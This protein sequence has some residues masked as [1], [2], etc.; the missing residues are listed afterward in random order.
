MIRGYLTAAGF[1][2][3][4]TYSFI[5]EVDYDKLL[6]PQ[7]SGLR[8]AVRILNPLGDDTNQMRTTLLADV[9]KVM[10][11]NLKRKNKNPRIFEMNKV[12]L[13]KSLPLTDEL[14][15]EKKKLALVIS[16]DGADFYRLKEAVENLFELCRAG[17][18]EMAAGG[19]VYFHPGRKALLYL[20]EQLVGELGE[21]HP[22]VLENF[23]LPERVCAAQVDLGA[24][25]QAMDTHIRFAPLPKYPA[26][27]RDLAVIV[28]RDAQ[29]GVIQKAILQ[30]GGKYIESAELFDVYEGQQLG[31][32]KKSLAYSLSFRSSVSTLAEEDIRRDMERILSSLREHFGAVLRG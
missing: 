11:T 18:P 30:A 21:I 8:R 9:L 28:D 12:Y 22:D 23:E 27:E 26:I 17:I 14:P 32:D 13:P 19:E 2:E 15:E 7:D 29:A 3:A 4:V 6:L 16:G 10:A 24:L 1:F 20:G 25:F 31:A 5:G